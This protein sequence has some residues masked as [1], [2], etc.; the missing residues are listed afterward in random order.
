L[1]YI[2]DTRATAALINALQDDDP[3]MRLAAA[4]ALGTCGD[5]DG[6]PA[7]MRS[8]ADEPVGEAAA[9]AL[10]Q[11]GTPGAE[12]LLTASQDARPLVR[13]KS[14]HGLVRCPKHPE[15]M[16]RAFLLA[17]DPTPVKELGAGVTVGACVQ[18]IL[19]SSSE[20]YDRAKSAL[21]A[22][23]RPYL[24]PALRRVHGINDPPIFPLL[25]GYLRDPEPLIRQIALNNLTL[26]AGENYGPDAAKWEAWW[27]TQPKR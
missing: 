26:I 10:A 11:L 25:V 6:I 20:A 16:N 3:A 15:A 13:A 24:V 17:V 8:L 21:K 1:G 18:R 12:A 27:E 7:L 14:A 2:H 4:R 9:I 22:N 19:D 5:P 23:D